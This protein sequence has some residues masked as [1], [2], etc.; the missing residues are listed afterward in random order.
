[1]FLLKICFSYPDEVI[2]ALQTKMLTPKQKIRQQQINTNK[3]QAALRQREREKN[4]DTFSE[5]N[6]QSCK[7]Y[8]S[9]QKK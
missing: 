8:R 4:P 1:M 5:K 9:K 2:T 6:K 3:H 7:C